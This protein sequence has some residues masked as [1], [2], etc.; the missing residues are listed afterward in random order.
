MASHGKIPV[1]AFRTVARIFKVSPTKSIYRTYV[2]LCICGGPVISFSTRVPRYLGR[3]YRFSTRVAQFDLCRSATLGSCPL[4]PRSGGTWTPPITG[5]RSGY[6]AQ[7]CNYAIVITPVAPAKRVRTA[8]A[9][10]RNN[11]V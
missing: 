2:H 4:F 1:R 11:N 3:R 9:M 6:F 10:N 8:H 7:H 5:D